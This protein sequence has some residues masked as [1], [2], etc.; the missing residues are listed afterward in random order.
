LDC[1]NTTLRLASS[2]NV[3]DQVMAF[4]A[5][6]SRNILI[7]LWLSRK[8]PKIGIGWDIK[9][10]GFFT[11]TGSTIGWIGFDDFATTTIGCVGFVIGTTCSIDSIGS[12][13]M[14]SIT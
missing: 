6:C 9:N 12:T 11:C 5:T 3:L 8:W 10:Y 2:C 1:S 13:W 14:L 4:W 7:C